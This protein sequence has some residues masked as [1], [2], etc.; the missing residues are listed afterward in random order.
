MDA[1]I[2]GGT[3]DTM[4]LWD[5]ISKIN[6]YKIK[7]NSSNYENYG[8]NKFREFHN[9]GSRVKNKYDVIIFEY[10]PLMCI[11]YKCGDIKSLVDKIIYLA[12]TDFHAVIIP[13]PFN[14]C[15]IYFDHEMDQFKTKH[16][17]FDSDDYYYVQALKIFNEMMYRNY[18]I[19]FADDWNTVND[20]V[21]PNLRMTNT[22]FTRYK[23]NPH[24]V[25][26]TK[27]WIPL[28]LLKDVI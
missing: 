25:V 1:L 6:N 19:F 3:D 11:V 21:F 14:S 28:N 12:K 26:I 5:N 4:I 15:E 7:F 8:R 17:E 18:N 27:E 2:V 10:C 24:F 20:T 16:E 9:L 22:R 23:Q 13:N